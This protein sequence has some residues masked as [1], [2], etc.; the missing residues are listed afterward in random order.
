ME[1]IVAEQRAIREDLQQL[2][3]RIENK[4]RG[5][6]QQLMGRLEEQDACIAKLQGGGGGGGRLQGESQAPRSRGFDATMASPQSGGRNSNGGYGG[7]P[8]ARPGGDNRG[9]TSAPANRSLTSQPPMSPSP[10]STNFQNFS[11]PRVTR[12]SEDDLLAVKRA[13]TSAVSSVGKT[14]AWEEPG[15][16]KVSS[17]AIDRFESQLKQALERN[18]EFQKFYTNPIQ[19]TQALFRRLDKNH[20]GKVD[21]QELLQMAKMLE[22]EAD[23]VL[24]GALFKRYD[25]DHTGLLTLDEFSRSLFKLDGDVEMKAKSAI[26]R[27]REVLAQRAG[28]YETLRALYRQFRIIDRDHSG[29]MSK[30]EWNIALD[31]LFSA[32]NVKFS[33]AEKNALFTMFDMDKSG[34]VSYDEFVRGVRGDMNDFRVD[35]VKQAFRIL[36]KDG[37]GVIDMNEIASVYDVSHNPAVQSGKT[38][39]QAAFQT[40]IK[41]WD[42]NEDGRVTFEEFLEN[43]QW[44]SS[45]I[46]SDD[47]FELMMRNAWHIVGGEGWC[48]NTSNLR[49][50]VKHS[51]GKEEV[52]CL[53]DDFAL[54][55]DEGKM[56][57][58]VVRRLKEQGVK[59][60]KK[61]EF[62]G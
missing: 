12:K 57:S 8:A 15:E 29:S 34:N 40:F 28:G 7:Y 25:L 56:Y 53:N 22:L 23:S 19:G 52:V 26:A 58:E 60:I 44:V 62:C 47:Y 10:A 4:Y 21:A 54:P 11:S 3:K 39:P 33:P 59:D 17:S 6:I 30:D 32:Y 20:S 24:M 13:A 46:D 27:M 55:R 37:S 1:A 35:W 38:T 16:Y 49:V 41:Q 18:R 36:D 5:E 14:Q 61:V 48:A 9:Q 43:Y 31:I 50:L 45:S 2:T 51:T 42:A